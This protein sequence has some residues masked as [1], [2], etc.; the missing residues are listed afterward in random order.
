MT[1][2]K[3]ND[4]KGWLNQPKGTCQV[5]WERGLIDPT[6]KYTMDG[7][8]GEDRKRDVSLSQTCTYWDSQCDD[9]KNMLSALQHLP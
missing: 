1:Y 2:L 4:K 6:K 5:L 3:T 8:K 9:F 7:P